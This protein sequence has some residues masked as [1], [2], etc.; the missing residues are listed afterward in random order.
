MCWFDKLIYARPRANN[1]VHCPCTKDTSRSPAAFCRFPTSFGANARNAKRR[2]TSS[3]F[4]SARH[5]YF[6]IRDSSVRWCAFESIAEEKCIARFGQF[7][8]LID[9]H[10]RCI[11]GSCRRKIPQKYYVH[12]SAFSRRRILLPIQTER[13]KNGTCVSFFGELSSKT[14]RKRESNSEKF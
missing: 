14:I 2:K 8:V 3:I 11:F 12:C 6:R 7:S 4:L 9:R 10:D 5:Y 1:L 13:R